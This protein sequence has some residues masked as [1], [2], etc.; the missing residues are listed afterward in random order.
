MSLHSSPG[1]GAMSCCTSEADDSMDTDSSVSQGQVMSIN[2]VHPFEQPENLARRTENPLNPATSQGH[3]ERRVSQEDKSLKRKRKWSGQIESRV[4]NARNASPVTESPDQGQPLAPGEASDAVGKRQKTDILSPQQARAGSNI[5][6]YLNWNEMLFGL[7]PPIWQRI[8]SYVPPVFLGRLLR[9]TRKFY[10]LLSRAS[11]EDFKPE[12]MPYTG[13]YLMPGH[14]I[15]TASRQRFAP[16]LPKPLIGQD[17][18]DMWRLLRG[19]DCQRCGHRKILMTIGN[20]SNAWHSGPGGNGVRVIWPF[21]IRSCGSCLIDQCEKVG[22]KRIACKTVSNLL[23]GSLV[24]ML[25]HVSIIPAAGSS[26]CFSY[27]V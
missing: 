20:D 27:A 11:D 9:V 24:A 13:Q 17:E 7:T 21:G 4:I 8:F 19:N 10:F 12:F 23:L 16:G 2:G 14:Y 15:W 25:K 26:M 5:A 3:G 18:L 1:L 6:S 22:R